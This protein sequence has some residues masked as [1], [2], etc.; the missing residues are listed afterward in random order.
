MKR[1]NG[2]LKGLAV[3]ITRKKFSEVVQVF[4]FELLRLQ[5]SKHVPENL[6]VIKSLAEECLD[7]PRSG[8]SEGIHWHDFSSLLAYLCEGEHF[9]QPLSLC[10][11]F[12]TEDKKVSSQTT[13]VTRRCT[14][15]LAL[16][17]VPLTAWLP[18]KD[19]SLEEET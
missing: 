4:D 12:L 3:S 5:C 11:D 9:S 18:L 14:I 7:N 17:R 13:P 6:L 15:N 19:L 2:S 10:S 16:C 1:K 8:A